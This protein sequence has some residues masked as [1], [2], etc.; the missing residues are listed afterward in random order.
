[1][2]K[3]ELKQHNA[4]LAEQIVDKLAVYELREATEVN[5]NE[6]PDHH[7][8]K[9]VGV[10]GYATVGADDDK[11][12]ARQEL[13]DIVASDLDNE[14]LVLGDS[15]ADDN[16]GSQSVAVENDEKTEQPS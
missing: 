14:V 1:M 8:Y 16:L 13:I 15:W 4:K 10:L 7:I 5:G 12:T 2:N 3:A 6:Y 11:E 9:L